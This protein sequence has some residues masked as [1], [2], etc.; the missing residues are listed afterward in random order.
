MSASS[1]WYF[2]WIDFHRKATAAN[3]ESVAALITNEDIAIEIWEAT[4]DELHECTKRLVATRR[5]PKF[6]NDHTDAIGTELV[7]LRKE[8]DRAGFMA[9]LPS[10]LAGECEQRCNRG[11]LIAPL[12]EAVRKGKAGRELARHTCVVLCDV[13]DMGKAEIAAQDRVEQYAAPDERWKKK[14]LRT[15]TQYL[16]CTK[17]V[18]GILMLR[19]YEAG[20]L[21]AMREQR[22][23]DDLKDVPKLRAS[24][25]SAMRVPFK[26]RA[27]GPE[28]LARADENEAIP[29]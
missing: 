22:K 18:D 25:A 2:E 8:R 7:T 14:K 23:P 3:A 29:A 15:L 27:R 16:E 10:H 13:C 17:Q 9:N 1:G 28:S 19:E 12:P 5:T 20:V 6:A 11:L 4:S 26:E 24:L 21:L